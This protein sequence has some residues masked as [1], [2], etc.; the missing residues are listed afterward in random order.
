MSTGQAFDPLDMNNY[1]ADRLPK[2]KK[3][4][5]ETWMARLG[6][7]LAIIVFVWICWFSHIGFIDNLN[8]DGLAATAAKRLGVLGPRH[9]PA[10]VMRCWRYSPPV[11]S[12]G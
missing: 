11:S 1:R 2:M 10:P 9:S 12:C 6:G 3:S 5:F 7:P 8:P 4:K